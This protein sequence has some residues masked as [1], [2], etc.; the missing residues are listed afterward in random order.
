MEAKDIST[1][2]EASV[3]LNKDF[4]IPHTQKAIGTEK[5]VF[6]YSVEN[7]FP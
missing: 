4:I 7:F 6:S 1:A 3:K 5:A 2:I